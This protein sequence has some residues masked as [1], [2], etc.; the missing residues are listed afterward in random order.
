MQPIFKTEPMTRTH[1]ETAHAVCL[2][3]TEINSKLDRLKTT[4]QKKAFIT[5]VCEKN[6]INEK[7]I[8]TIG[9]YGK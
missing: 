4:A 9:R 2:T 1:Q 5:E 8:R 7:H 6:N 3:I